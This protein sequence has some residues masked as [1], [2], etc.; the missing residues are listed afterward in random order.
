M[1][2]LRNIA[3]DNDIWISYGGVQE[4]SDEKIEE[5]E[6]KDSLKIFNSH[7]LIDNRG[8]V[9]SV[10]RKIHLFDVVSWNICH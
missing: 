1:A 9:R 7:L 5:E 10:Y 8:E 3:R 6:E 4:V 2:Q